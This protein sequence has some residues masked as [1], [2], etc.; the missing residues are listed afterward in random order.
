MELTDHEAQLLMD[1]LW[2]FGVRPSDR[3]G[4]AGQIKAMDDHLQDMRSIVFKGDLPK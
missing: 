2:K 1:E 3:S 4:N